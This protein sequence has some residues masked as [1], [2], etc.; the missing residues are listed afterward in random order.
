MSGK[1][2]SADT[3]CGC[4]TEGAEKKKKGLFGMLKHKEK[5]GCGC[6]ATDENA[7]KNKDDD[8]NDG[9]CCCCD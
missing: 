9:G 4:N 3:N 5:C 2:N 7:S 8:N 6:G 1:C